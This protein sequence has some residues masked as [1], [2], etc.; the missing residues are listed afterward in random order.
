MLHFKFFIICHFSLTGSV[1]YAI[2]EFGCQFSTVACHLSFVFKL[3][4]KTVYFAALK[5]NKHSTVVMDPRLGDVSVKAALPLLKKAF[6][7]EHALIPIFSQHRS[8]NCQ[9]A[10]HFHKKCFL[11]Q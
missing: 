8:V 1:F 9:L 6:N 7:L 2:P 5:Y 3:G 10:E 11:I 4:E